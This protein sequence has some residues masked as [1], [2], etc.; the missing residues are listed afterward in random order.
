MSAH[1]LR[2][3]QAFG[4]P[5][6][7]RISKVWPQGERGG[8]RLA[9]HSFELWRPRVVLWLRVA[10]AFLT[11]YWTIW[12]ADRSLVASSHS[13]GYLAF[14]QSFPLADAWLAGSALMAAAA[15]R[16]GRAS[17]VL[18]LPI[19]GGAAIYLGAL[20]VLYDLENGIYARAGGG[21]VELGINLIT[22]FSGVGVL[23]FCWRFHRQLLG[24]RARP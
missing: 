20:D 23:R 6:S 5:L 19:V 21:S 3:A 17:S 24:S 12:F 4:S 9:L 13:A 11:L 8:G 7:Q 14:E 1:C 18:W 10:A 15:L 16:A 22:I 2:A